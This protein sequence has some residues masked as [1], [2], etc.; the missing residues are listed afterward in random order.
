MEARRQE[1][2][3]SRQPGGEELRDEA[4]PA[5]VRGPPLLAALCPRS[6]QHLHCEVGEPAGEHAPGPNEGGGGPTRGIRRVLIEEVVGAAAIAGAG[7]LVA[8]VPRP[9]RAGRGIGPVVGGAGR[10]GP[11]GLRLARGHLRRPAARRRAARRLPRRAPPS[12]RPERTPRTLGRLAFGV[13][14]A[15]RL[16]LGQCLGADEGVGQ[17]TATI[18]IRVMHC[19]CLLGPGKPDYRLFADLWKCLLLPLLLLL[20][21]LWHLHWLVVEGSIHRCLFLPS[22]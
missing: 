11:R 13:D 20:L 2:Q 15:L 16:L 7:G 5:P 9:R 17:V 22:A 3:V 6:A 14:F 8:I 19:V 18:V 10:P 1:G 21:L 4:A 12:W